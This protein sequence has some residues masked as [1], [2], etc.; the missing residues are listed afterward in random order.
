MSIVSLTDALIQAGTGSK[1]EID[2][3]FKILLNASVFIP[4]K[5]QNAPTQPI[6]GEST[7]ETLPYMF[8][9]YEE[10][11]CIPVFSEEAFLQHWAEREVLTSEEVFKQFIWR[12][13]Q[14]TWLYLNPNQDVG[15][16]IS[17][18]E[19]ELLKQGEDTIPDLVEGVIETE[20]EDVEI[21]PPPQELMPLTRALLPI[22]ELYEQLQEAYLL[23][24]REAESSS[25]RALVG[26]RYSSDL[27]EDKLAYIRLELQNA[28]EEH[29]VRPFTGIFIVDDLGVEG[30]LNQNL[31]LDIAPFYT[32]KNT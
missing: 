6:V 14:N 12:L 25:P 3:F 10:H 5:T 22:L 20:Q 1:N 7:S 28:A 24:I 29:L 17:P 2:A 31:F 9:E 18:W 30:S 26:I 23:S 19:I 8:V 11:N 21:E 16:E 4:L 13:P 27:P 32:R 15:K